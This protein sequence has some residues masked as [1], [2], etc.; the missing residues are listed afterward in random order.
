MTI[1]E[2]Y[3][4]NKKNGALINKLIQEYPEEWD[5]DGLYS[6]YKLIKKLDQLKNLI[7]PEH[8]RNTCEGEV[9]E[10]DFIYYVDK[11]FGVYHRG[12]LENYCF[13]WRDRN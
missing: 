3:E 5:D 11:V 6:I 2:E 4:L 9:T 10:S 1:K 13:L 12:E 8:Y 7:I